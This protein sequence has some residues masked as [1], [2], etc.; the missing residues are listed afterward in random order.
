[1]TMAKPDSIR[2]LTDLTAGINLL[3]YGDNGVGKTP[4]LGTSPDCLILNADAPDAVLSARVAGSAADVWQVRDWNDADEAY[5]YLRHERKLPYRWVWLDS[6][7]GLQDAG[8]NHIMEDLVAVKKHRDRYVPDKHE[9]LQNMNRLKVWVRQ[10]SGLPIN[11]GMTA[12]PFRWEP[13]EGEEQIWPWVQGK[14][15]PAVICGYFN[16]IGYV[17]IRAKKDKSDTEQVLYTRKLPRYYARD[18][19]SAIPSPM[20]NPNIPDIE[21]LIRE[22]VGDGA[23]KVKKPTHPIKKSSQVRKVGRKVA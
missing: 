21:R 3:L 15:M 8:L 13:E 20:T 22:K 19:F 1:M 2:Q 11:F 18:R 9:Y 6:V 17:R 4:I 7:S 23:K 14:G 16:V 5:E 10:M 12:H